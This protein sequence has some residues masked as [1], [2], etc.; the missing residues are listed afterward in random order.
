MSYDLG[1]PVMLEH[2]ILYTGWNLL[3]RTLHPAVHTVKYQFQR[4]VV[5]IFSNKKKDNWSNTKYNRSN[6]YIA[7][8][9][10]LTIHSPKW[11]VLGTGL[12]CNKAKMHS[13][14]S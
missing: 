8:M 14:N 6:W 9:G 13:Y 12:V 4:L 10:T 11:S 7:E 5:F 2:H 1:H 3:A